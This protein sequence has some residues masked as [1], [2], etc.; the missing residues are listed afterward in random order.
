MG[1]MKRWTEEMQARFE[2]GTFAKIAEHL[3]HGED[4]TQFVRT[5]VEQE[6]ARRT[7][8]RKTK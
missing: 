5:A 8:S 2:E 7:V 4:R 1:R 3:K 6:L